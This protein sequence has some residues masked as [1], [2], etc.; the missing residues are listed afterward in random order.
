MPLKIRRNAPTFELIYAIFSTWLANQ[1]ANPIELTIS[2]K[3]SFN[4]DHY[5]ILR[6]RASLPL[7]SLVAKPYE[8]LPPINLI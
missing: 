7:L 1:L 3:S 4:A 5:A 2:F 6:D 8:W